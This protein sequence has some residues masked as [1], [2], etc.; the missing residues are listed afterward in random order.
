MFEDVFDVIISSLISWLLVNNM[1]DGW[2]RDGNMGATHTLLEPQKKNRWSI[3]TNREEE[4]NLSELSD[5]DRKSCT[6]YWGHDLYRKFWVSDRKHKS[7][8][9]KSVFE[10]SAVHFFHYI[11]LHKDPQCTANF[12]V[13]MTDPTFYFRIPQCNA[14]MYFQRG[15]RRARKP[16]GFAYGS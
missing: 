14:V 7:H 4:N 5:L 1:V 6:I 11:V 16:L 15:R 10:F 8:E 13:H 9:E 12:S 3:A 2:G